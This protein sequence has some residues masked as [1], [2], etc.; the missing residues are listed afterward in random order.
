MTASSEQSRQGPAELT[1]ITKTYDLVRE[2]TQRVGKFPRDHRFLLGDR[3]LTNAYD[4]L[5]LL[6]NTK[7]SLASWMGHLSHGD[8]WGLRR[9]LLADTVFCRNRGAGK[10]VN[11]EI[12]G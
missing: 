12:G 7:Q 6:V 5:G 4:V 9:R 8:T 10:G 1:A 11:D 3:I 2:M